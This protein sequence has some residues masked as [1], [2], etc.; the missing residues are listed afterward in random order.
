MYST[1]FPSSVGEETAALP[2]IIQLQ[3]YSDRLKT[4]PQKIFNFLFPSLPL[5]LIL[6]R[7]SI[8]H[9]ECKSRV[10]VGCMLVDSL[11][12]ADGSGWLYVGG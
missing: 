2:T 8:E 4:Q 5:G 10:L 7:H 6:P 12:E 3:I 1:H 11:Q 9:E